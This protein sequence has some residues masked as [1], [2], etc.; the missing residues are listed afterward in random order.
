MLIVGKSIRSHLAQ[1]G[2]NTSDSQIHLCQL[3]S[4]VGVLLTIDRNLFLISAVR[5]NELDGLNKHTAGAAARVIEDTVVWLQHFSNQI[6][7]A[8]RGIE[9]TLTFT[10]SKSKLTEKIFIYTTDDIVL[11]IVCIYFIDLIKQGS[12]LRRIYM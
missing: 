4:S 2:R 10:F 7:N 5:F 6:Y 8:L 1:I 3:E 11:F 12:Q 9:L